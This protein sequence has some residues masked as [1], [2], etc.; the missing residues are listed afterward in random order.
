MKFLMAR[1]L[2]SEDNILGYF[3]ILLAMVADKSVREIFFQ[4]LPSFQGNV[5]LDMKDSFKA[6]IS[7]FIHIFK[8]PRGLF[9]YEGRVDFWEQSSFYENFYVL[10]GY[11]AFAARSI[12]E[13]FVGILLKTCYHLYGRIDEDDTVVD[14]KWPG[15]EPP[16]PVCALLLETLGNQ[17]AGAT[18]IIKHVD[19]FVKLVIP[20][21]LTY[22]DCKLWSESIRKLV[23]NREIADALVAQGGIELLIHA[24][25]KGEKSENVPLASQCLVYEHEDFARRL[26]A[27]GGWKMMVKGMQHW[28]PP[29]CYG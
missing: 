26:I 29:L 6:V 19:L 13:G 14:R 7:M 18:A 4:Q 22:E 11:E 17:K 12:E 27:E 20:K 8:D 1:I 23:C 28:G 3:Y 24:L 21:E 5:R 25:Q 15:F 2:E 9:D 10:C 16:R